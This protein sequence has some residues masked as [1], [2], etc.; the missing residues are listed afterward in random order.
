MRPTKL[1]ISAFGPFA[2]RQE[3]DLNTLGSKGIY[4]ITGDTG[5]GKTTI[6]DA[7][8]YALFGEPSGDVRKVNMLRSDYADKDTVTEVILEFTHRGQNY[9]I[10]RMPAQLRRAQRVHNGREYTEKAA[11]VTLKLPDGTELTKNNDVESRIKDILGVD[12]GQFNQIAMIAQGRFQ[13]LLLADTNKRLEIFREIFKT[14][15]FGIFE[16]RIQEENS[17]ISNEYR[18]INNSIRQYVDGIRCLPESNLY[19]RLTLCR[20]GECSPDEC[21]VLLKSILSEE[22]EQE[23]EKSELLHAK[24]N[25]INKLT[26]RIATACNQER[27]RKTCLED[28]TRVSALE[29]VEQELSRKAI[30]V[31]STN[32]SQ[33]EAKQQKIGQIRQALP[34]YDQL[35]ALKVKAADLTK[36]LSMLENAIAA[37]EKI[38]ER[39][40]LE[41]QELKTEYKDLTDSSAGIERMKNELKYLEECRR[42]LKKL[43]VDKNEYDRLEKELK[44]ARQKYVMEQ[45]RAAEELKRAQALRMLFNNEQAGLMAETLM[46][47]VPCPVCGSTSHPCKAVKSENAPTEAEVK[48][49]EKAAQ[50]AQLSANDKSSDASKCGGRAETAGKALLEQAEKLLQVNDLEVLAEKLALENKNLEEKIDKKKSELEE[51]ERRHNRWIKLQKLIPEKEDKCSADEYD[52]SKKKT[53]MAAGQTQLKGLETQI[54]ELGARLHFAD[55]NAALTS[56]KTLEVEIKGLQNE[57]AEAEKNLRTCRD[58]LTQRRGNITQARELLKDAEVLDIAA[59]EGELEKLKEDQRKIRGEQ[60]AIKSMLDSNEEIQKN[61]IVKLQESSEILKRGSWMNALSE[62]VNGKLNGKPRIRL[63]TYYQMEVFDRIII[64][65]NSHLM[66]MSNGKYDLKR[67]ENYDTGTAQTGLDLN[68]I[69]HYCGMERSV[70]SLS[71]GETFMASLSLALG[72]SEEIQSTAGGIV[73]DTMYVDEGFGTLDEEALQQ[74]LKALNGLTEGNRLIGIISHVEELRKNLEKQIVVTRAGKSS[75]RGSSAAI[76]A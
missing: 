12:R 58:E 36:E 44:K 3:L 17:R 14:Q 22:K 57:I 70:K 35:A 41:L 68:V 59:A 18:N 5:A 15:R 26:A 11:T 73:L 40:Q 69:D 60:Q 43:E 53:N 37:S 51:G 20:K 52:L 49:A 76:L 8:T 45:A 47:G 34:D 25:E 55:R 32:D 63:E 66:R 54:A 71:G 75:K 1:I 72:F 27:M 4:L 42:A 65:A 21:M 46:D 2:D 67:R 31:K 33:I 62:T 28:Q 56:C 48:I 61:L 38:R 19:A 10:A 29:P 74:A 6:F 7:I 64:R 16:K 50:D 23:K 24:D 13:E 30:Q 9:S 39:S